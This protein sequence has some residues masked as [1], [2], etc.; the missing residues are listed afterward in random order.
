MR[1]TQFAMGVFVGAV[2]GVAAV[3]AMVT[4]GGE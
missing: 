2:L 1:M 4:G 3:F